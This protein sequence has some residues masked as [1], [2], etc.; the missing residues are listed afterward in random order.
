MERFGTVVIGGGIA[1]AAVAYFL[2]EEGETDILLVERAHLSS[3]STGGSFGGVRQ[4]FSTPLEIEL[5]RRGLEF[6]RHAAD[7]LDAQIPFYE[8][9]YL[10]VTGQPALMA[11]LA[12][13]ARLQTDLGLPDVRVLDAEQVPEAAPWLRPDGLVGGCWT[14]HDGRVTPPDGVAALI[15][16]ARRCGA[17]VRE[18]WPVRR[19]SRD[20]SG[21]VVEGPET[22]A[23]D[24]VVACTGFWSS[25]FLRP[26]GL[27]LSIRPQVLLG[28]ITE[29]ALTAQNVPLTIDLDTGFCV[30]PEGQGLLVAI[31]L[32]ENPPRW[33]HQRMLEEFGALARHR[34]PDL[35]E[36]GIARFT[37]GDVDLGGDGHPYV[38]EVANGLWMAAGF[39]GHGVMHAPAVGQLLAKQIAGQADPGLDISALDP[40]RPPHAAEEWMVATKK[41]AQD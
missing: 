5:S 20:G 36:V 25:D 22:V 39:G 14:P 40:H 23:A 28:A 29:P 11:K 8:C 41:A 9:G 3:G 13:A 26:F 2:T 24:R 34:A 38:G 6:W 21:W 33:N 35:V 31:L 1:G 16:H 18:H 12:E 15:R 30:E 37:T 32:E 19:L 7:L 4:Q 27:D 17:Q 10:F